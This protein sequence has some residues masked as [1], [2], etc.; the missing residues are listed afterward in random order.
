MKKVIV[1]G[2]TGM[3][4]T[5]LI[6]KLME[7]GIEITVI[8]RP[9]TKRVCNLP[10]STMIKKVFCNIGDIISLKEKLDSNYDTFFHLA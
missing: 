5:T 2:G 1:T 6:R 3:I 4:G 7:Y 8:V 9:D 10:E